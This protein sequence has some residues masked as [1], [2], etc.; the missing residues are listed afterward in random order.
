MGL[1]LIDEPE[2]KPEPDPKPELELEP[3]P[4]NP[5]GNGSFYLAMI[6]IVTIAALIYT[7]DLTAAQGLPVI[8]FLL[9][10]RGLQEYASRK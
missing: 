8:A 2:P 4:G 5:P 9:G 1:E 10:A 7:G 6:G 3:K